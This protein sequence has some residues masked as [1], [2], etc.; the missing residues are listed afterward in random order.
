MQDKNLSLKDQVPG[1]NLL[2]CLERHPIEDELEM[3]SVF[4]RG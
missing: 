3:V 4:P 1:G 2:K